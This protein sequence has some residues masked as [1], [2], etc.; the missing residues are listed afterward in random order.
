MQLKSM[1]S[2]CR[3]DLGPLILLTICLYLFAALFQNLFGTFSPNRLIGALISVIL[4]WNYIANLNHFRIIGALLVLITL[5]FCFA[6]STNIANDLNDSIYWVTA[7]LVLAYIGDRDSICGLK[8]ALWKYSKALS[9]FVLFSVVTLA[10]LLSARIGYVY[11]WGGG[12]YFVGLCNTE[13]TM[14]AV[15][16]LIMVLAFACGRAKTMHPGLVMVSLSISFWAILQTGART[17]LVPAMIIW[18]YAIYYLVK[19]T[20]SKTFV[21]ALVAVA[22]V[23]L[24]TSTGM[25]EKFLYASG[26]EY[27]KT[28][29]DSFTSGRSEFW[30]VDL[31][32]YASSGPFGWLFGNSFSSVYD[33]N[34]T[35]F[36]MRIWSHNDFVMLLCSVGLIGFAVYCGSII[37]VFRTV[38]RY[39]S[40]LGLAAFA[41]Y[42]L[43][44][45]IFNGFY[46]NQHFVYSAALLVACLAITSKSNAEKDR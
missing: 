35:I 30:T 46:I 27:A 39:V 36:A 21:A 12:S 8:S 7:M 14:S 38:S 20:W 9:F 43:F 40:K 41:L 5:L 31:Q 11:S 33:A 25:A 17:Y 44:P 4:I 2:V 19:S 34:E 1:P 23:Y 42:V 29:L 18:L 24:F 16:C 6:M 26:N 22:V 15:C 32:M 28:F 45:A 13:H 10:V 37:M 3:S